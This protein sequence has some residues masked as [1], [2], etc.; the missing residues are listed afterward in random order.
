M[1]Q[2]SLLAVVVLVSACAGLPLNP[3]VRPP[4]WSTQARPVKLVM[5]SLP[6]PAFV[7]E[8]DVQTFNTF[9]FDGDVVRALACAAAYRVDVVAV[10]ERAERIL[11]SRGFQTASADADRVQVAAPLLL[12]EMPPQDLPAVEGPPPDPASNAYVFST[13]VRWWG[14]TRRYF[15]TVKEPLYARVDIEY[16]LFDARTGTR[17]WSVVSYAR[18]RVRG[19][20]NNCRGFEVAIMEAQERASSDAAT[21]LARWSGEHRI[22]LV[23]EVR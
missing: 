1:K 13:S 10:Q 11:E 5:R 3:R 6:H 14:V 12:P 9:R 20:S 17:L 19:D 18:A 22:R 23:R 16:G 8:G 7:P 2:I 4:F 15:L 21:Q